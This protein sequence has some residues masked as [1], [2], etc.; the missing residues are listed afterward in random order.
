MEQFDHTRAHFTPAQGGGQ[1]HASTNIAESG[2]FFCI[3]FDVKFVDKI[4]VAGNSENRRLIK[5]CF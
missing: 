5:N 3:E 2:K 1:H 4:L